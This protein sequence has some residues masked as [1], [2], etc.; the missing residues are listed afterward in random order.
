MK[1]T[2]DADSIRSEYIKAL[3]Q[4]R[5]NYKRDCF[6]ANID[7][8]PVDTSLG[9]DKALTEYLINRQRRF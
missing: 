7:Y 6:K 2:Y 5:E 9:F 4:F 8:V 1:E 3:E